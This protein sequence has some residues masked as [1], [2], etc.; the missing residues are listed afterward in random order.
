MEN[1][2]EINIIAKNLLLG[3]DCY[4]CR[5]NVNFWCSLNEA[6][7][8]GHETCKVF[9]DCEGRGY[10]YWEMPARHSSSS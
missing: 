6:H 9:R 2:L 3:H 10:D 1:K 4:S 5:Y 8:P 7:I